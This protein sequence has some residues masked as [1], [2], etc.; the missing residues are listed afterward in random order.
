MAPKRRSGLWVALLAATSL[1]GV[2]GAGVWAIDHQ[3]KSQTCGVVQALVSTST[4]SGGPA[5]ADLKK[6]ASALNNRTGRL[7]FHAGLKDAGR[8]LAADIAA[9]GR[10]SS[11]SEVTDMLAVVASIND[12]GRTAQRECGIPGK[13]VFAVTSG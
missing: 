3:A 11:G 4:E 8:G 5:S 13:D 6:A 1:A 2:A 12:H 10:L 7:L 9:L